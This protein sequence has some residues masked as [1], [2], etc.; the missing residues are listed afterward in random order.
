MQHL[1]PPVTPN[2]LDSQSH[3]V[4]ER[5]CPAFYTAAETSKML[6]L[7]ESTLYRHLRNGTFPGVKIGGRYVVPHAVLERLISDVLATGRCVDLAEWTEQW[8]VKQAAAVKQFPGS[9]QAPTLV[10]DCSGAY[11]LAAVATR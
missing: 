3:P 6:R 1:L 10:S 9:S 2:T 11:P 7:D 8:Q 4:V 5:H